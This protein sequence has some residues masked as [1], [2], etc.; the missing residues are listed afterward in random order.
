MLVNKDNCVGCEQCIPY[1]PCQAI[2]ISEDGLA[3]INQ[4]LCYECGICLIVEACNFDALHYPE[5]FSETRANRYYCNNVLVKHP[6]TQM[7]GRGTAE[8]KTN[9]ITNRYK[10]GEAGFG[11][12]IGRP[13]IGAT[14]RDVQTVAMALVKINVTFEPGAPMTLLMTDVKKGIFPEDILDERIICAILEFTVPTP[15]LQKI[16]E[17]LEDVAGEID[18]VFSVDLI[19]RAEEDGSLPNIEIAKSLGYQ[20]RPNAKATV[21]LARVNPAQA[22]GGE[23][24]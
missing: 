17:A 1:C 20:V 19:T 13:D 24:K 16:L 21:G 5:R 22:R 18:T 10:R 12:E 23:G 3:Q 8:M 4:D 11:I 7:T 15:Q 2:Y 14:F 9:D 6:I